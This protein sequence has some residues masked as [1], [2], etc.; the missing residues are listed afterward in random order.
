MM[1]GMTLSCL[2]PRH[3]WRIARQDEAFTVELHPRK[4]AQVQM[5]IRTVCHPN[6][7]GFLLVDYFIQINCRSDD[8][9]QNISAEQ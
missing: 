5:P 3:A 1:A 9:Y 7:L 4:L 8:V 2:H 6:G